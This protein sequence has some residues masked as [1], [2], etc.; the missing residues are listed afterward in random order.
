[1]ATEADLVRQC[2]IRYGIADTDDGTLYWLMETNGLNDAAALSMCSGEVLK[3][4]LKQMQTASEKT[5]AVRDGGIAANRR[6]SPTVRNVSALTVVLWAVQ[7]YIYQHGQVADE[8]VLAKVNHDN[9]RDFFRRAYQARGEKEASTGDID[10]PA[11]SV[12][13]RPNSLPYR[14]FREETKIVLNDEVSHNGIGSLAIVLRD[15]DDPTDWDDVDMSLDLHEI[16]NLIAPLAGKA[17]REDEQR[18]HKFLISKAFKYAGGSFPAKYN[19]TREAR[20]PIQDADKYYYPKSDIEDQ[21]EAIEGFINRLHW[22][23][24][25]TGHPYVKVVGLLRKYFQQLDDI[26]RGYTEEKKVRT[27]IKM[28]KFQDQKITTSIMLIES[29]KG[30]NGKASDFELAQDFLKNAIPVPKDKRGTVKIKAVDTLKEDDYPAT[31]DEEGRGLSEAQRRDQCK[32]V[33]DDIWYGYSVEKR[34]RISSD[35]KTFGISV[36]GVGKKGGRNGGNDSTEKR[37]Y[38]R[39]IKKLKKQANKAKSSA[40]KA[41]EESKAAKAQ[42][43]AIQSAQGNDSSSSSEDEDDPDPSN[44]IKG[45]KSASK[46]QRH[47]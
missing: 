44:S 23:G 19:Q 24:D 32:K 11:L 12:D 25:D 13:A 15:E 30:A 1:M 41:T 34:R 20:K 7:W 27:L 6:P 4:V 47:K 28:M 5:Q 2:L 22:K 29:D 39:K 40:E 18:V 31:W 9:A 36:E 14:L 3:S 8:D 37:K 10:L 42:L 46:K 43:A 35:R 45:R 17:W 16:A 33:S 21:V 38:L 26:G